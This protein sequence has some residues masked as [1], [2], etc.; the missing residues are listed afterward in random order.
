LVTEGLGVDHLRLVMGTSMGGMHTW[1][2][3]YLYPDFMDAL[4]P[5]A[6]LPVQIAGRNRM[7]R[8]MILDSIRLDPGWQQGDYR[9]QPFGLRAAVHAL[10]FMISVPLAWQEQAPTQAAADA[11]FDR[12]VDD[13]L[14]RLDAN[15]LLYQVD[16]SHDYDPAPH[17]E[18]IQAPLIA[19]NSADDQVNPPELGILEREIRRVP[20][21]RAVVLPISRETQGHR[22]HSYPALWQ[23]YLA[24]LLSDGGWK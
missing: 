11:L 3:G 22:S 23:A 9:E 5:L 15:D 24:K 14:A 20:R 17:L 13:F 12:L 21:G 7:L 16:A 8:R 1:M 10:I 4:M 18:Q 6:S 2:W 19:V